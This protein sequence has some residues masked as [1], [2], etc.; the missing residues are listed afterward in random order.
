MSSNFMTESG[1][2]L[3]VD[4]DGGVWM[5]PGAAIAHRGELRFERLPTL[6]AAS[7]EDAVMREVAPLVRVNGHGRLFCSDRAARVSVVDLDGH[8]MVVA[9]QSVLAFEDT[10]AFRRT[11]LGHGLGVAAGGLVVTTFSGRGALAFVTR[12]ETLRLEVSPGDPVLTHPHATVAWSDALDPKLKTDLSWR[13]AF[14]HGGQEPIQMLFEGSGFVIVQPFKEPGRLMA[15]EK[16]AKR[17]VALV[18]G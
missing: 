15:A 11:L 12:G 7:T 16:A 18:S 8:A 3:R 17:L 14:A 13:S 5:K 4:V 10:L 6:D 9:A 1:R 2:I